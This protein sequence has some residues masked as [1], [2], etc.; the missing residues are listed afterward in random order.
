MRPK[1]IK[2]S[3]MIKLTKSV[4]QARVAKKRY[5]SSILKMLDTNMQILDEANQLDPEEAKEM[6]VALSRIDK[7]LESIKE[8]TEPYRKYL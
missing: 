1:L 3:D 8:L 2:R 5:V 7:A 4:K 6:L